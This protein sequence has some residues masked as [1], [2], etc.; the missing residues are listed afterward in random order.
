M[1]NKV[2]ISQVLRKLAN[3][4]LIPAETLFQKILG[5]AMNLSPA[6]FEYYAL[7][8]YKLAVEQN[9]WKWVERAQ[10]AATMFF[11][12]K[13]VLEN[14][15]HKDPK[16]NKVVVRKRAVPDAEEVKET[17]DIRLI[18]NPDLPHVV[19]DMG[20]SEA[21]EVSQEAESQSVAED[22]PTSDDRSTDALDLNNNVELDIFVDS[23][24]SLCHEF[25]TEGQEAMEEAPE[26]ENFVA[27]VSSLKKKKGRKAVP[28]IFKGCLR[29]GTALRKHVTVNHLPACFKLE[30][31]KDKEEMSS[32]FQGRRADGLRLLRDQLLGP[33]ESLNKLME[34]A[35]VKCVNLQSATVSDGMKRDMIA[36]SRSQGWEI[37]R[38]GFCL[39]PINSPACLMHWRILAG[40]LNLLSELQRS[41]FMR[42]FKLRA[43]SSTRKEEDVT[44]ALVPAPKDSIPLPGPGASSGVVAEVVPRTEL[45]FGQVSVDAID[46]HMHQD[47]SSS[48]LW[49]GNP[50]LRTIV[51]IMGRDVGCQPQVQVNLRGAVAVY[52]DPETYPNAQTLASSPNLK[53]AIGLHPRKVKLFDLHREHQFAALVN[54]PAVTALGEVGYDLTEPQDTWELQLARLNQVL[55]YCSL[56]RVLVL[57]LRG[58]RGCSVNTYEVGFN[59]CRA[60][61]GTQQPIH[62]HCFSGTKDDVEAWLGYFPNTHFG[63]T[64]ITRHFSREQKEG[65]K[66]VPL[67]RL[68]LETDSPYLHP[69]SSKYFN[70]P[71]FLGDV[72]ML[73]ANARAEAHGTIM[74]HAFENT[75]RLY[76]FQC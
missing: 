56:S 19:V 74:A 48:V 15:P 29:V 8:M 34:L 47:R 44:V 58:K 26:E 5:M 42:M 40:L 23:E 65:L 2:A 14:L 51:E 31:L 17:R 61:C 18:A 39:K 30:V 38:A 41:E 76:K 9:N 72:G 35:E 4:Q 10:I 3:K 55:A 21:V 11:S 68:L 49:G 45:A 66:A 60:S 25:E 43:L 54:H 70:T 32:E 69:V 62:L 33:K 64:G 59:S 12:D 20:K 13:W 67:N 52:C 6:Q 24:E 73:V 63:F 22:L 53:F 28:C 71:A 50:K 7:E 36:L 16:R 27:P 46:S 75:K 57:H 1:E 37:P